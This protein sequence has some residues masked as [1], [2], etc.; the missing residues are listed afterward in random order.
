MTTDTDDRPSS[1][2]ARLIHEYGLEGVG[3]E[4]ETRWTDDGADRMSLRDLAEYFNK[5]LL[6]ETLLD[7]GMPALESDL[8]AT[9]RR[10][11][12][13]D[14]SA[15]VRT[16]TSSRLEQNG[17]NVDSLTSDFVTYQA[18]RSYLKDYRGA[19][20]QSPSDEQKIAKDSESIQRL[21]S[22]TNSVI[23]ER[24]EWLRDTDRLEI[25]EFQVLLDA[26]V[27]CQNCGTQHTV[28]DLLEHGGCDCHPD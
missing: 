8:E 4:L 9:Y 10:L 28:V 3:A 19:T 24:V 20:H 13:E 15:G 5:Q 11:T 26:Q 27:L 22:R 23:E 12:S 14:V 16:E 17:I 18:M 25:T 6:E 1:K 2:V 7:A 21:L